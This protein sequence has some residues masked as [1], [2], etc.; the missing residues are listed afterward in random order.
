M[1]VSNYLL[2]EMLISLCITL[3]LGMLPLPGSST[4]DPK[5]ELEESRM[6]LQGM[7]GE[8]M[9]LLIKFHGKTNLRILLNTFSSH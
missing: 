2:V 6:K 8:L 3:F 5:E 7:E 9:I 4:F 1:F